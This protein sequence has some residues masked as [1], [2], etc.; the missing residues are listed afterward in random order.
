MEDGGW[1]AGF[2]V[3]SHSSFAACSRGI[4]WTFSDLITLIEFLAVIS[5]MWNL[6]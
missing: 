1:L 4:Y 5:A 2:E 6:N 3:L